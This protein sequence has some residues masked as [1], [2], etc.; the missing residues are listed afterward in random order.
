MNG[1]VSANRIAMQAAGRDGV[2]DIRLGGN[3][4]APGTITLNAARDTTIAGSVVSDS[5]LN[6]ATQRNLSVGGVVGSTKGNVSL[7]ARTGR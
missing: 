1:N 4:G 5:D 7:T 6:L 3:V 2:G